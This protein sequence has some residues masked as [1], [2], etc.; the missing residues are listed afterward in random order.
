MTRSRVAVLKTTPATVVEDY[1][2]LMRLAKYQSYLP[3]D[4]QTALKINASWHYFYPACSTT[5][6]QLDGVISTLL[7]DGYSK[8]K[9]YGC[10]NRTVVVNA[11]RAEQANH[12]K[13]VLDWYGVRN[14]HLY[15]RNEEWQRR[16]CGCEHSTRNRLCCG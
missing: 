4:R 9:I 13:Q 16:N 10:Q 14:V 5:P 8:D 1:G 11:K 2:R 7:E 3:V 6:W 12:H 15:E